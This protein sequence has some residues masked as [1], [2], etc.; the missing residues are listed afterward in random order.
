MI[1]MGR[2]TCNNRRAIHRFYSCMGGSDKDQRLLKNMKKISCFI[3]MIWMGRRT[4]NKRRAIHRFHSC[5]GDPGMDQ[6]LLKKMKNISCFIIIH[7]HISHYEK[8]KLFYNNDFD[9]KTQV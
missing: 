5:M 1:W 7:I 6:R 4:R 9:V 2:R 8:D 3:V